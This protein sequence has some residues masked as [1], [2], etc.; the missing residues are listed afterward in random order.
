M[1][2]FLISRIRIVISL[3]LLVISGGFYH[4]ATAESAEDSTVIAA[5]ALNLARFTEWP[6]SALKDS[7]AIIGLCVMGDNVTQQAFDDIDQ[8]QVGNRALSVVHISRVKNVAQCQLLYIGAL[9]RS[10]IIQ[11]L[12]E[13]NGQPILTISGDEQHFLE[14]GGM[15]TLKI[16]AGK[17]NMQINLNAVKQAGLNIS[18]RVL[19]LATLVNP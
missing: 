7:A 3:L 10:T 8:K 17:V 19:K 6:T 12:A 16:V 15:V 1:R 11:L 4:A 2:R 14:D 9:D 13:I 5:L 18:S